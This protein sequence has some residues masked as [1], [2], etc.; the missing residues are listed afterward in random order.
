[1]TMF[2]QVGD[3]LLR[4]EPPSLKDRDGLSRSGPDLLGSIRSRE[5]ADWPEDMT[6]ADALRTLQK[7]EDALRN[8]GSRIRVE[9]TWHNLWVV[10]DAEDDTEAAQHHR[11]SDALLEWAEAHEPDLSK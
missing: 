4:D 5:Y 7:I 6:R 3:D 9:Q 11:V 10:R 2:P 1:M 8:V